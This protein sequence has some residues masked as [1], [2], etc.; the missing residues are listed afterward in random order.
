MIADFVIGRD[1]VLEEY[2]SVSDLLS[3]LPLKA[4][5]GAK[6]LMG[7][8]HKLRLEHGVQGVKNLFSKVKETAQENL[9]YVKIEYNCFDASHDVVVLG[10]NLGVIFLFDRIRKH[11]SRL[12]IEVR[13]LQK[14]PTIH[15]KFQLD[16]I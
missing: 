9:K 3:C 13:K 12:V 1:V 10:T 7:Q 14:L 4:Q 8:V 16:V 6:S 5:H 2:D 15:V 11:L